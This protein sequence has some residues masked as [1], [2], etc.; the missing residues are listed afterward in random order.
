VHSKYRKL[1]MPAVAPNRLDG[2]EARIAARAAALIAEI[3]L[4]RPVDIAP[5]LSAPLP[6]LTL[7]KLLGLPVDLLPRLLTWTNVFVGEGDTD[8]ANFPKRP[9]R[10]W[11]NSSPSRRNCSKAVARRRPVI[12]PP[13]SQMAR[14]MGRQCRSAIS[15]AT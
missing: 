5:L 7:A 2:I 9:V 4:G 14:S 10:R 13:C 12:S 8:F 1:M 6:L 15:S 11:A 3:T